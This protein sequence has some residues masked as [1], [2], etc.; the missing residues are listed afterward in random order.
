VADTSDADNARAAGKRGPAYWRLIAVLQSNRPLTEAL[1][2]RLYHAALDL[3]RQG[4]SATSL[5][6]ELATGTVRRIAEHVA[7]GSLTGPGFE[8]DLETEYGRS[9]VRFLVT[10]EGLEWGG[11]GA[12]DPRPPAN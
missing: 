4:A 11:V 6:G 9:N 5:Q 3:E 2:M 12:E 7:L 1:A 10:R 8:A